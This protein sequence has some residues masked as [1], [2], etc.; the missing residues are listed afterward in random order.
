[1]LSTGCCPSEV[2]HRRGAVRGRIVN[3]TESAKAFGRFGANQQTTEIEGSELRDRFDHELQ[4]E[5]HA[6]GCQ[7]EIADKFDAQRVRDRFE[8]AR[9]KSK[10][11]HQFTER[12]AGRKRPKSA[13]R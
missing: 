5:K 7:H 4:Q 11:S 1:M 6:R 3:E 10:K 12:V 9:G 8:E 13:L 2:K